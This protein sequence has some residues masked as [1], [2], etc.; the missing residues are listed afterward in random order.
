[1]YSPDWPTY[2][3]HL[4]S[5]LKLMQQH[6][7][8]VNNKKCEFNKTQLAYLGH[9]ISAQGVVVDQAKV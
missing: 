9:V 8:Y 1:M 4:E 3:T 7:L 5:V 2:V 6:K